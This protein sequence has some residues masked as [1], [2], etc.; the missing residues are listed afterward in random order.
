MSDFP[1]TPDQLS[2]ERLTEYLRASGLLAQGRVV[3][4]QHEVIGTGK[5]GDNARYTLR[6]EGESGSAPSTLVGKFPAADERARSLAGA[7]GAYYN[8]VMFYREL[9]PGTSMRT[10]AM[11]ASEISDDRT[12]FLLLME[13][14]SPAQPGSQLVGESREHAEVALAEASR[15]GLPAFAAILLVVLL[16]FVVARMYGCG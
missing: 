2:P 5:M 14:M 13:D 6:Y 10:P 12:G 1:T 11:H 16:L 4:A 15:W 8:E 3:E 7:Q 9:A